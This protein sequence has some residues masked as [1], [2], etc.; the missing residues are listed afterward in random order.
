MAL[1]QE[2]LDEIRAEIE[3]ALDDANLSDVRELGFQ[4]E[5]MRRDIAWLVRYIRK[6]LET[7]EPA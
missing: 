1:E 5:E 4:I 2:D 6:L 7:L 3:E